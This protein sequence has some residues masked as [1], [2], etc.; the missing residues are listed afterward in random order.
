[1]KA[2]HNETNSLKKNST[3]EL[4]EVCKGRKC[5]KNKC[6]FKIKIY[7]IR[8]LLKH[9]PRLVVKGFGQKKGIDFDEIFSPVMKMTFVRVVLDLAASMNLKLEQMN[10][11]TAFL[12]GNLRQVLR[13]WYKKFDSFMVRNGYKKTAADPCVYVCKFTSGKFIILLFLC[14]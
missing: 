4:V 9:K 1:M 10:V 8:K 2:M 13:Q 11:K 14:R 3:Y 12:H 6:V 5:L 7:D